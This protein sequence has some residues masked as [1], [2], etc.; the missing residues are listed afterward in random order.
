MVFYIMFG[1]YLPH[2]LDP[3]KLRWLQGQAIYKTASAGPRLVVV[4][5][6]SDKRVDAEC[7]R[8]SRWKTRVFLRWI[9]DYTLLNREQIVPY[10]GYSKV[11]TVLLSDLAHRGHSK[12]LVKPSSIVAPEG[13]KRMIRPKDHE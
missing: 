6:P 2:I 11:G 1:V 12:T 4:A 10:T 9:Y 8:Q 3:S 13:A 5:K 7:I